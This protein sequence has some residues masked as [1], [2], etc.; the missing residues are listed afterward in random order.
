MAL[1]PPFPRLEHDGHPISSRP[2]RARRASR[3]QLIARLLRAACFGPAVE[4]SSVA[5]APATPRLFVSG[6]CAAPGLALRE[7]RCLVPALYGG[8]GGP[9]LR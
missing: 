9:V 6:S 3:A 8:T 4:A 1:V 5:R 7:R 2:A